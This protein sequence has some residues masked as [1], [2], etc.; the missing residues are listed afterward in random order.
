MK[1]LYRSRKSRCNTAISH[2]NSNESNNLNTSNN[3]NVIVTSNL[4]HGSVQN[5]IP[6]NKTITL[7]KVTDT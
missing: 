2:V 6:F 7:H 4:T 3:D 1:F 5:N